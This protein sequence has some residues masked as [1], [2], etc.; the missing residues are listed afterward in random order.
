[1]VVV[2]FGLN[3]TLY[4][5]KVFKYSY[6]VYLDWLCWPPLDISREMQPS[7][8]EVPSLPEGMQGLQA[9]A[10]PSCGVQWP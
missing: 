2:S 8:L 4:I 9:S 10:H 3:I 6:S 7:W 1:M 5:S